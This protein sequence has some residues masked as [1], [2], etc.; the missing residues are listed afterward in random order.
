MV[1]TLTE[2]A[3]EIITAQLSHRDMSPNEIADGLRN[4]FAVLKALRELELSK[5][6]ATLEVEDVA[7]RLVEPQAEKTD[8]PMPKKPSETSGRPGR[9]E[10]GA[11][12]AYVDPMDSIQEEKIICL[13]CGLEFKQISHTHLAKHGMTPKDYRKK[14]HLPAKQAL[15]AR[16]LSEKR[17]RKAVEIGLGS[18][19]KSLEE[20]E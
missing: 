11:V 15:T 10:S 19:L 6:F 8:S 14:Y 9:R 12:T 17:K 3:V 16:S 2:M 7:G 5:Q 4:T 18:R 20:V 13:E 1:K